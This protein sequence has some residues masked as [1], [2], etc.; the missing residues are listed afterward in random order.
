MFFS[1]NRSN[2]EKKPHELSYR[3][4]ISVGKGL[5]GETP[6]SQADT[7]GNAAH[8]TA[9]ERDVTLRPSIPLLVTTFF[10]GS[11]RF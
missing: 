11:R 5:E 8:D 1:N 9:Q 2:F 4:N 7:A 10:Y 6:L 3:S